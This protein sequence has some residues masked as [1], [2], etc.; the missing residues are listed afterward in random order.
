MNLLPAEIGLIVSELEFNDESVGLIVRSLALEAHHFA[1]SRGVLETSVEDQ[2]QLVFRILDGQIGDLL[3]V[4]DVP[5]V[6]A[7]CIG[8]IALRFS[9]EAY[10]GLTLAAQNAVVHSFDGDA[11]V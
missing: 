3:D 5:A 10:L 2:L 11:N 7:S 4:F 9:D 1:L 6:N 8:S